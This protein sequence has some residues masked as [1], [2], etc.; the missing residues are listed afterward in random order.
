M[1]TEPLLKLNYT[2]GE[3]GMMYPELQ[4]SKNKQIDRMQVGKF[5]KLWKQY[6]MEEHPHRLSLLV[7]E[8]KINEMLHQVDEEAETAKEQRI[9]QHLKAQPMPKSE[10][11][12]KRA[13]HMN[14]LTMI[15]EEQV[16]QEIVL[17]VR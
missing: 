13:A 14:Q 6:M 7:A 11:T 17:K 8:G 2:Q 16:I 10:D 5:G 9:Q 3:D 4:I 1:R 12:L 15:A